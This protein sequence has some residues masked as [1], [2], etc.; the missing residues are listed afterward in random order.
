M[1][2]TD[3]RYKSIAAWT[4]ILFLVYFTLG[5]IA[6]WFKLL[7]LDNYLISGGIIGGV[8]S[9]VGLLSFF[10]PAMTQADIQKLQLESLRDIAESANKLDDLEKARLAAESDINSLESQKQQMEILVRKAS[11]SLFLQEQHN[12]YKEKV[13]ETINQNKELS[14]NLKKL[15]DINAKLEAL[16]VEIQKD[17]N[18]D[19]LLSI[20]REAKKRSDKDEVVIEFGSPLLNV[21]FKAFETLVNATKISIWK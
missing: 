16:E 20:I 8:V 6:V 10:R 13:A 15:S 9:V 7:T 2:K 4:I 11:L 3:R 18:V 17:E 12:L 1:D 5:F 19:L 14:E 21:A